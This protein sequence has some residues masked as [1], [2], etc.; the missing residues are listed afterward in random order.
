M[1][2]CQQKKP[3]N[4]SVKFCALQFLDEPLVIIFPLSAFI[5]IITVSFFIVYSNTLKIP[6]R[7]LKLL[8]QSQCKQPESNLINTRRVQVSSECVS[9]DYLE[10]QTEALFCCLTTVSP[11]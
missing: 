10:A 5:S 2:I 7:D 4:Y 8:S 9:H 3:Q 11:L 6:F 1:R